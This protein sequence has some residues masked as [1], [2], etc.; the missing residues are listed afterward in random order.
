MNRRIFMKR[1]FLG[2]MAFPFLAKAK[3][4][5]D[6]GLKIADLIK[7]RDQLKR[8]QGKWKYYYF[9]SEEFGKA[10]G[11]KDGQSI[12]NDTV[13][14]VFSKKIDGSTLRHEVRITYV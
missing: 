9:M 5:P 14:V 13:R 7:A 6:S 10:H 4:K 11:L 2:L 3:A 1:T 8:N 12:D